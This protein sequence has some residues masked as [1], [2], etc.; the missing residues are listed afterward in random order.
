[1]PGEPDASGMEIEDEREEGDSTSTPDAETAR[2]VSAPHD[3]GAESIEQS[4]AT[5]SIPTESEP[6][7]SGSGS[8]G[9]Q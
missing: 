1:L 9:E 4:L 6:P 2:E 7:R 5:E 8:D 3:S